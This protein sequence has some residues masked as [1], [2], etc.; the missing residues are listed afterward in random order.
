MDEVTTKEEKFSIK[1]DGAAFESH[2]IPVSALAQSLLSLDSLSKSMVEAIYGK[3]TDIDVKVKGG[4]RPGSFV[5]DLFIQLRDDPSLT[6]AT[7]AAGFTVVDGLKSLFGASKWS[8]GKCVEK[9]EE[10][11]DGRAKV[12]NVSGDV[13][14]YN[15]CVIN[16]LNKSKTKSDLDRLTQTLDM[17]GADSIRIYDSDNDE[18]AESISKEDRQYLRKEQGIVLT[19]NECDAVLEVVTPVL[20]GNMSGWRFSEGEGGVEFSARVEDEDF[21]S[22]VK[23]GEITFK[24]GT[25]IMASIRTV[26]R[27]NVR[28]ITDRTI[29]VVREIIEPSGNILLS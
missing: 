5:V 11:N 14:Y 26:Q 22:K 6:I 7:V 23:A 21:L 2:E 27:K 10:L 29:M 20:N 12:K 1:F 16:V 8:K 17:E 28:T 9:I 3:G 4:F 19:D 15:N 24:N 13:N 25:A 18:D